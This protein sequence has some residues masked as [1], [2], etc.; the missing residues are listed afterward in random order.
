[1]PATRSEEPMQR[2]TLIEVLSEASSRKAKDGFDFAEKEEVTLYLSSD[3]SM[4]TI[5]KIQRVEMKT[6]HLV[7]MTRDE[8]HYLAF[9]KV[10]AIKVHRSD[11][12]GTGFLGR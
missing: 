6:S 11:R 7:V 10:L 12:S 1:M 8:I 2:D 4:I 5:E 3:G 9:D